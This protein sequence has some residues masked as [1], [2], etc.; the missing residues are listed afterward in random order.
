V[1][2]CSVPSR[3]IRAGHAF[4]AMPSP[5]APGQAATTSPIAPAGPNLASS[6]RT[7]SPIRSGSRVMLREP[8]RASPQ[9]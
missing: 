1:L 8:P 2:T 5:T 4:A 3:A 6:P 7:A 9:R